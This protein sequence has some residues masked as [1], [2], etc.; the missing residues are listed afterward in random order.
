MVNLEG[1]FI[2]IIDY[3]DSVNWEN[4]KVVY[5]L[6]CPKSKKSNCDFLDSLSKVNQ[7][8]RINGHIEDYIS[9]S[10]YKYFG[11]FYLYLFKYSKYA[12]G[13]NHLDKKFKTDMDTALNNELMDSLSFFAPPTL[14]R[15]DN[16]GMFIKAKKISSLGYIVSYQNFEEYKNEFIFTTNDIRDKM[17]VGIYGNYMGANLVNLNDKNNKVKVFIPIKVTE[18]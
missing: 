8:V 9:T 7:S 16:Y 12:F 5:T 18:K 3:N 15:I 2:I 6:A 14:E 10:R 4:N 1:Y 17:L 13:N 11:L